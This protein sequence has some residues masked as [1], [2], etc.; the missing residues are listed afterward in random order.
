MNSK[1]T[2]ST[3]MGITAGVIAGMMVGAAVGMAVKSTLAPKAPAKK[4]ISAMLDTAG[5]V[6]GSM[7]K[8]MS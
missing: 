5:E 2:T 6:F 8:F 7:A 1:N 3:A 4:T